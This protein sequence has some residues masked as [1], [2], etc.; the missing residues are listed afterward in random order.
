M[1]SSKHHIPSACLALLHLEL[2]IQ[3]LL[4]STKHSCIGTDTRG[5]VQIP[6]YADTIPLFICLKKHSLLFFFF[7]CF[8]FSVETLK[9]LGYNP[10]HHLS[11][12]SLNPK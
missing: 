4:L 8:F 7:F 2:C 1:A 9:G 11:S 12:S 5:T 3:L 6:R 10:A